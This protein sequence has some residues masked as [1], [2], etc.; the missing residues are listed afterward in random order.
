MSLKDPEKLYD[1]IKE[2]AVRRLTT[3]ESLGYIKQNGM[4]LSER[5]YR[6]YKK[7]WEDK[8]QERILVEGERVYESEYL[9]R[10][11]TI[12]Q[13]EK[14]YWN[15]FS[16]TKNESLKVKILKLIGDH[17]ETSKKYFSSINSKSARIRDQMEEENDMEV[18][19]KRRPKEEEKQRNQRYWKNKIKESGYDEVKPQKSKHMLDSLTN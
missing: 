11:D 18:E 12:K 5:T 17:Q 7:K 8:T 16:N 19:F 14:Y 6:R 13:V 15:I 9:R 3:E 4:K 1:L 2:C 10:L